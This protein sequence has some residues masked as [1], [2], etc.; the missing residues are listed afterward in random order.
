MNLFDFIALCVRKLK[1]LFVCLL[2]LI[3][4]IISISWKRWYFEACFVFFGIVFAW[5]W[6][7]PQYS[8]F[9]GEATIVFPEGMKPIIESGIETF[10]TEPA[11]RVGL[12]VDQIKTMK[13][14]RYFNNIDAKCDSTIDFIDRKQL[15]ASEDT[16]CIISTT[17]LTIQMIMRSPSNYYP[18]ELA[19]RRYFNN[20]DEYVIPARRWRESMQRKIDAINHEIART[21]S[22]INHEYFECNNSTLTINDNLA[23]NTGSKMHYND[24]QKLVNERERLME[25]LAA[26]PDVINFET[27]FHAYTMLIYEKYL[28]S[29]LVGFILGLLSA[30]IVEYRKEILNYLHFEK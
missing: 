28:Y 12:T 8:R 22:F 29:M 15:M 7:K 2:R 26:T 18:Y 3:H 6:A 23:L 9:T 19:L 20:R 21:D 17:R 30:Y 14:M 13:R 25:Q 5:F 10:L 24:M 27:H 16:E 1:A 11:E 4:N